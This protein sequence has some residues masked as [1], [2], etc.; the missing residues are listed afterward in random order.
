MRAAPTQAVIPRD[1]AGLVLL[2][3]GRREREVLL[4]R[5]RKTARFLPGI[6][7][8]PGGRLEKADALPSGFAE[9]FG[10]L[11]RGLDA[12]T[13]T[14]GAALLRAALRETFEETGI[15]L[16]RQ[17]RRHLP[18]R[19]APIWQAYEEAGLAPAFDVP[20]L[21]ARAITPTSSPIRFHTRFYLAEATGLAHG[22]PRDDELEE[23]AW[24]PLSETPAL[25]MVDVTEFVLAHALRGP[26]PEAP[27]FSY[28]G[29]A[30][31]PD[32]R[33]VMEGL[34]PRGAV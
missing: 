14:R 1:A 32:L 25:E 4:G 5:R 11:P 2:R 27:L 12:A 24:V 16:G 7:V 3:Q 15:L 33:S 6:W 29:D 30:V 26:G 28:R 22:T 23:V 18:A 34:G 10:A 21:L 20:R 13:R 19:E 31:R 9:R 8:F 17:G